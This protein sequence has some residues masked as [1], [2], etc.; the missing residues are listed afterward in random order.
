MA[1]ASVFG[2]AKVSVTVADI[3]NSVTRTGTAITGTEAEGWSRVELSDG[4]VA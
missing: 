3:G 4:T 2:R 1:A